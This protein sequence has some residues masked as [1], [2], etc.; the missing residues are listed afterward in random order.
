MQ[1]P[2]SLSKSDWSLHRKGVIDQA[3]HAEKVKEAI[4]GNLA[5]IVAEEAIVTS[6]GESIIKVPLRSLE[7]PHFRYDEQKRQKVGQG[8][9]D[10]G[11]GDKNAN[12]TGQ[13]KS[14][15]GKQA[16]NEPGIDYFEAEVTIDDLAD[17]LF[18]DLDLPNLQP[19]RDHEITADNIRYEDL[20]K[21]GIMNNLDKRRTVMQNIKRNAKAGVPRFHAIQPDDM[22]F[23]TWRQE[24]TRE[25][26]AVIIA[27]RDVS[28]SMG[29][30]EKY[31]SRSF[32][33]WMVRF[34]RQKYSNVNIVFIVH[35]TE[36]REVDE[37]TFFKLGE[38]GGTRVSSAYQLALD[39]IQRRYDP[40]LWNIYP[41]HFSDGDNWEDDNERSIELVKKLIS[42]CNIFGYGEIHRGGY[43]PLSTLMSTYS[44]INDDKF[45]GV[46]IT[47]KKDVY[48]A[49]RRFFHK[50]AV[51]AA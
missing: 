20:R 19:K 9:G 27:M 37:E 22:R 47:G 33:F 4:K 5:D 16:G 25:S 30:F 29:E 41:F 38:S 46:T 3:R 10:A 8:E 1:T 18:E 12:G 32:Y 35:H 14:A 50:R 23:R 39:T 42:I 31:I 36:A 15:G 43:A 40:E 49:L 28:A 48:P 13:E 26:N 34:L 44:A 2:V 51:E 6:N 11:A 7:L 45:I 17:L 21:S 24:I